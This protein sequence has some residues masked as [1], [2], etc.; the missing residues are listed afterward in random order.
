MSLTKDNLYPVEYGKE[1][2]LSKSLNTNSSDPTAATFGSTLCNP[3]SSSS[4]GKF[5]SPNWS[6]SPCLLDQKTS[7]QFSLRIEDSVYEKP[8]EGEEVENSEVKIVHLFFRRGDLYDKAGLYKGDKNQ[9]RCVLDVDVADS[10]DNPHLAKAKDLIENKGAIPCVDISCCSWFG[11]NF[12]S[13][14]LYSFMDY[15]IFHN[16]TVRFSDYSILSGQRYLEKIGLPLPFNIIADIDGPVKINFDPLELKASG[17][18]DLKLLGD[19]TSDNGGECIVNALRSTRRMCFDKN[20]DWPSY[21]K[22]L[23]WINRGEN[24]EPSPGLIVIQRP[25]LGEASQNNGKIVLWSLHFSALSDIGSVD[26]LRIETEIRN[27]QGLAAATRFAQNLSIAS[28]TQG[29]SGVRAV[30]S[31]ALSEIMSSLSPSPG[32]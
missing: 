31:V 20:M 15:V 26:P 23:I 21:A 19:V 5:F 10:D 11:S 13:E 16:G 12:P 17:M 4:V 24:I 32:H 9:L 18:E 29:E 3:V 7:S 1:I 28:R 30:A 6:L 25:G 27:R 14:R 22:V 8:T 2:L